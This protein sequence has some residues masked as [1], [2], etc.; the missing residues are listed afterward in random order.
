MRHFCE[1]PPLKQYFSPSEIGK[2]L[3]VGAST[4]RWWAD[5]FDIKP[6]MGTWHRLYTRE[7]VALLHVVKCLLKE[8][9]YTIIGARKKLGIS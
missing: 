4:I 7:H 9:G 5:N 1:Q 2:I 6:E 8:E 3:G